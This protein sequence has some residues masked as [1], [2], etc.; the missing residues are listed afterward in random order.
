MTPKDCVCGGLQV[1]EGVGHLDH[2]ND[3]LLHRMR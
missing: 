3:W 2:G 1:V